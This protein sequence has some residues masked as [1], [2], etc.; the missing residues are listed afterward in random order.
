[1]K[2]WLVV[3]DEDEIRTLVKVM[4]EAWGHP[5]LEFRD[6]K[7]A[8]GWLDSVEAGKL[9]EDELPEL[10]LMDIR[11]PGPRGN[12]I[13]RR[14]RGLKPF[15]R[16]PIVLMTAFSLT[17]DER[18]AMYKD[19]GVDHIISKP[20]PDFFELKQLLEQVHATKKQQS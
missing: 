3:E 10:A 14:M 15:H 8:F 13:A 18:Q 5:A 4:F 19:C 9:R 12:E 20:L 16:I 2:P 17:E 11:M 1:V 6:G 7:Q